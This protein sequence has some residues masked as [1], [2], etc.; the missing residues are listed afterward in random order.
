MSSLSFDAFRLVLAAGLTLPGL[1]AQLTGLDTTDDGGQLYFS[2]SLQL[3]GSDEF[4]SPKIFR[5]VGQFELF[6]QLKSEE[7][8]PGD[9]KTNLYQLTDP[10]VTGDGRIV[11][12]TGT[13]TCV[14][15]SRCL[16]F[17]SQAGSIVGADVPAE[18]LFNGTIRMAK[19]GKYAL[20]LGGNSFVPTVAGTRLVDV[21]TG[22]VTPLPEYAAVGDARQALADDGVI[23]LAKNGSPILLRGGGEKPLALSKGAI[24]ARLS[25]NAAVVVYETLSGGERQLIAFDV[26]AG[27]ET[28][29]A[30]VTDPPSPQKPQPFQPSLCRDGSM[31]AY[32]AGHGNSVQAYLQD[33]S[34]G[35]P[36][37]LTNAP[38]GISSVVLSGFGNLAYAATPDNALIRINVASGSAD[39][40]TAATPSIGTLLGGFAPGSLV[41]LGG[42]GFAP[43][44]AITID[45][46]PAPVVTGNMTAILLQV[47][48]ESQ[49]WE[50]AEIRVQSGN[51]ALFESVYRAP[52][53]PVS[54]RFEPDGAPSIAV[55][56]PFDSLVT[57]Q[58]PARPGEIIHFYMTGLGPVTPAIETGK[59]TPMGPLFVAITKP[60]CTVEDGPQPKDATVMFA[61]LAPG[62]VG[63]YQV[64]IRLPDVLATSPV[65][66]TCSFATQWFDVSTS[67]LVA[68]AP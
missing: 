58:N 47:P 57:D 5:Y 21:A 36:R 3:K 15:G 40:L 42:S 27:T 23:L 11:A 29:L 2:S 31:V 22:V 17:V 28:L 46:R 49:L 25:R 10:E 34:G 52:L 62:Y 24:Q 14:G 41:Y 30:T 16:D 7:R 64:D 39:Q 60:A 37:R 35:A 18:A 51:D 68:V 65:F 67:T 33:T 32:V 1:E 43:A 38:Q 20:M 4:G 63:L 6:R 55:H 48:W 8:F 66:V 61:G 53:A 50:Q 59:V 54:P 44:P 9:G 19:D 26:A 12:Y 13:G 45:G 56:Q